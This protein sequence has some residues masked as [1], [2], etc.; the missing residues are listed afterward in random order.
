M[1]D[2]MVA[3]PDRADF[4]AWRLLT[5]A[6]L[7]QVSVSVVAQGIPTLAP[8]IQADLDLTRAQVGLIGATINMGFL[9][10]V[11]VAGWAVDTIGERLVMILGVT[12]VLFMS[13]LVSLNTGYGVAIF[14]L[15]LLGCGSATVTPAGSRVVMRRF[16]GRQRGFAMGIRQ[17]GIPLGG[18]IA[19]A[20][21]PGI[22]L[23]AGWRVAL[24]GAGAACALGGAAAWALLR[25]SPEIPETRVTGQTRS[26]L[27][28]LFDRNIILVCLGCLFMAPAQYVLITYLALFLQERMGLPVA[29]GISV[30][31][32][33]QIAGALSRIAAGVISDRWFG[34]RRGP[35]L[36]LIGGLAGAAAALL[37]LLPSQASPWLAVTLS[38]I[39]GVSSLSWHGLHI[40]IAA[41]LAHPQRQGRT[42]AL[43]ISALFVGIV[44]GPPAF[45]YLVDVSDSYQLAWGIVALFMWIGAGFF[46]LVKEQINPPLIPH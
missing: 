16:P 27:R 11:N 40:T 38:V 44:A 4:A 29:A 42:V 34:R 23:V 26:S 8:F 9:A 28:D 31:L 18:A 20:L 12:L 37:A 1:Q 7:A 25:S 13:L 45:G 41:E 35:V 39:F 2:L 6:T 19:A 10:M 24:I 43:T 22:A 3:G 33:C 14:F 32:I 30:L 17:T 21:L 36:A 5:A 15:L 46:T